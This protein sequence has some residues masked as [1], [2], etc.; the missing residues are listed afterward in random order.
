MLFPRVEI[1]STTVVFTI[2]FLYHLA[3]TAWVLR[4]LLCIISYSKFNLTKLNFTLYPWEVSQRERGAKRYG[5][6]N[7]FG[8]QSHK[9]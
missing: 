6:S 8:E 3:T 9:F 4:L 2:T 1:E 5:Y 7:E